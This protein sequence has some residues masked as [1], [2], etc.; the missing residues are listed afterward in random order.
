MIGVV[1]WFYRTAKQIG[2]NGVLW[3]AMGALS[4]YVPML[5]CSWLVL[6]A[7]LQPFL[8][9]S[10]QT[11]LQL[12]DVALSLLVGIGCCVALRQILSAQVRARQTAPGQQPPPIAPPP[13]AQ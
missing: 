4:Y 11:E 6:P 13:V 5:I 9:Y 12:L 7:F 2:H 10:N 8:T 1:G 3:G